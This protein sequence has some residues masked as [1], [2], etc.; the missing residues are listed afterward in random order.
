MNMSIGINF[1]MIFNKIRKLKII[2]RVKKYLIFYGE[3]KKHGVTET[4]V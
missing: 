3:N 1:V 2:E 4:G